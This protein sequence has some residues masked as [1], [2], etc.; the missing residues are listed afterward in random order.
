LQLWSTPDFRHPFIRKIAQELSELLSIPPQFIRIDGV[1]ADK[2]NVEKESFIMGRE[3][4]KPRD[5]PRQ[6]VTIARCPTSQ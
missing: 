2:R 5:S 1:T 6:K 3:I 4:R